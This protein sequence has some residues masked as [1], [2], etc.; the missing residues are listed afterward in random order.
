ME[1]DKKR[2]K[3]A[4][5]EEAVDAHTDDRRVAVY[6]H[7]PGNDRKDCEKATCPVCSKEKRLSCSVDFIKE[8]DG[9]DHGMSPSIC[10]DCMKWCQENVNTI[11]P[12]PGHG[13]VSVN[14]AREQYD[15]MHKCPLCSVSGDILTHAD[16]HVRNDDDTLAKICDP[17]H[18][19]VHAHIGQLQY[20]VTGGLGCKLNV[21]VVA[22]RYRATIKVKKQEKP[23]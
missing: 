7:I 16:W 4:D 1:N 23:E 11:W 5:A 13:Y 17:C 9:P 21:S 12:A 3:T 10:F 2:A 14:E 6:Q 8:A 20:D 18:Y 22:E 15:A 19:F